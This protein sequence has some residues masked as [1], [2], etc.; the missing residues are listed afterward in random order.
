MGLLFYA[1]H[2][3]QVAGRHHLIRID[4]QLT[5]SA[6]AISMLD[7]VFKQLDDG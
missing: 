7:F 4:A 5:A 2:G 6:I 1:G 3:L